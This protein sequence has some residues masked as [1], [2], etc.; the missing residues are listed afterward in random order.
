MK[1]SSTQAPPS[2]WRGLLHAATEP[3]KPP[4]PIGGLAVSF[5]APWP[6]QIATKPPVN[7][8]N[9]GAYHRRKISSF[10]GET[11]CP[12]YKNYRYFGKGSL[13]WVRLEAWATNFD[14]ARPTDT[15]H[16]ANVIAGESG[17]FVD[18]P[19]DGT[20]VE[21]KSVHASDG[22]ARCLAV[23]FMRVEVTSAVD[24]T[25]TRVVHA[26]AAWLVPH[27]ARPHVSSCVDVHLHDN[28]GC[29]GG[30]PVAGEGLGLEVDPKSR[31]CPT[32]IRSCHRRTGIRIPMASVI[33]RGK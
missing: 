11:H 17:G 26:L 21:V 27:G 29:Q 1:P 10:L 22:G 20:D 15:G 9:G 25:S 3:S 14:G 6:I 19:G 8:E 16:Y 5:K 31:R 13:R 28:A 18:D 30:A 32:G 7:V 4:R 23:R 33:E 24:T 2:T 12:P